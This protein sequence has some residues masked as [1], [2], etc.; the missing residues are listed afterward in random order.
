MKYLQV[1]ILICSDESFYIGVTNNLERR[2]HEHNSGINT[3]SYT[4]QRRPVKLAWHS[5]K[6]PP[7]EAIAFEKRLKKWSK[8]KKEA[9]IQSDWQRLKTLSKKKFTQ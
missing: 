8:K 4:Y 7:K 9:L 5:E 2:L 6:T 1:Y 3:D